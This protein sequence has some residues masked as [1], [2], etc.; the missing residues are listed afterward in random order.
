MIVF[1]NAKINLGLQIT[2]KRSDG[3][4]NIISCFYPVPWTDA[5]EIIET[6]KTIFTSSGI[7]IPD[8]TGGN[9]CTQAYKLLDKDYKLPS[10][11]IHLHKSIPIG[12]GLG[13]G[14]SDA[15]YTLKLLN[16]K[17]NLQLSMEQLEGYARKLGSDCAFFIQNTPTMAIEKGDKFQPI[18]MSLK[19]Y[20]IAL[21]YPNLHISTKEAYSTVTPAMPDT[22]L[23]DVLENKP[24]SKWK[25]LIHNDFE[26]GITEKHPQL[27]RLKS[28]LYIQGAVYASMTGSGSTFYGIFDKKPALK[29]PEEYSSFI[30]SL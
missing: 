28:D 24:V 3:F 14:S 29:L 30:C 23:L 5:L 25:D 19:G 22:T 7:D 4:H 6:S 9:L 15:A 27:K 2:N 16:Q 12:A 21:I 11:H 20:H 1:P 8:S 13:G 26:K 18:A 10:V 17:F